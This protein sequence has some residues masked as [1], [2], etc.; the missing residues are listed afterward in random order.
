MGITKTPH[1]PRHALMDHESGRCG[2]CDSR[3]CYD[4]CY[5]DTPGYVYVVGHG[6][7]PFDKARMIEAAW[8]AAG[9]DHGIDHGVRRVE[10]D[11]H[12]ATLPYD[13]TEK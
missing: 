6:Y 9:L 11:Q 10:W 4:A 2:W 12:P 3:Y 8:D 1:G 13:P 5:A 7:I